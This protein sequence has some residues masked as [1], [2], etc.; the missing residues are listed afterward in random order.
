M[1]IKCGYI[2]R[3]K[4]V[5]LIRPCNPGLQGKANL[6]AFARKAPLPGYTTWPVTSES[7]IF[8]HSTWIS[9]EEA[10]AIVNVDAAV[11][12]IALTQIV[13]VED[14]DISDQDPDECVA[15]LELLSGSE[16]D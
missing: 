8:K 7:Q 5:N 13:L 6:S 2:V 12:A 4:M 14:A 9:T 3:I 10:K 11:R 16:S 1:C 15:Q